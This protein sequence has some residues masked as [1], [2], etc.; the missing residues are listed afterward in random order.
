MRDCRSTKRKDQNKPTFRLGGRPFY[1]LIYS[2]HFSKFTPTL[3]QELLRRGFNMAQVAADTEDTDSEPFRNVLTEC[4]D[5]G[6]PV[7]LE[8]NDWK[9]R[10]V[11]MKR[12]DL[13]MVMSDGTPVKYF[14]DYANPETRRE[15]LARYARAAE[16]IKR[17]VGHPI[18]AVSVGAYD[19]YHLPDGE[20]HDDFVVPMH[21]EE[22]QTELPYGRYAAAA[23]AAYLNVTEKDR[24]LPGASDFASQP[25]PTTPAT[26]LNEWHWRRWLEFRRSL[27]TS[28]LSDT[29]NAVRSAIHVP[30]GVS[31]DLNFAQKEQFA[32]PPFAWSGM[33]DFVSIYCYGKQPDATLRG[34]ADAYGVVGIS[35]C[36]RAHDRLSGIFFGT[37]GKHTRRRLCKRMCTVCFGP[38]DHRPA[39]QTEARSS[40]GRFV[41]PL[42]ARP[43]RAEVIAHVRRI[44]RSTRRAQPRKY[45]RRTI[46]PATVRSATGFRS[47]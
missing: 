36:R 8:M 12:P 10:E 16:N 5:A 21:T 42:G 45:S 39:A 18:V 25:P 37:R 47:M 41:H 23:F 11:L 24:Q 31:I 32:T 19:A 35:R 27:V 33:L 14:P 38:H 4:A 28:W 34:A 40:T 26:A 2:D 30:V 6:V 9:L 7:L 15:H 46:D 3:L 1:P 13:N 44:H 17:F 29:V 43:R 20:V 22:D